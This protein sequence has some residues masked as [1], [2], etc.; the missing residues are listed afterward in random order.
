[1]A[2]R[3]SSDTSFAWLSFRSRATIPSRLAISCLLLLCATSQPFLT[4]SAKLTLVSNHEQ[5]LFSGD[6]RQK[7]ILGGQP[8]PELSRT[9][10]RR[11]NLPTQLRLNLGQCRNHIGETYLA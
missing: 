9:I 7:M 6:H 8:L 2:N 11:V 3:Q 4:Q 10:H 5:L 1:M